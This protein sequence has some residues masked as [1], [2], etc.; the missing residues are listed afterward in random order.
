MAD[1]KYSRMKNRK[2]ALPDSS[3]LLKEARRIYA[4]DSEIGG[5]VWIAHSNPAHPG[6]AKIGSRVGGDD[7]HGY[8]MCKLLG[9]SFKVHQVV[10][11]MH[12]GQFPGSPIDHRD[13]NRRNNRIENLR[14]A[15][16]QQNMVNTKKSLRPYCGVSKAPTGFNA[17][18]QVGGKKIY[19]GFFTSADEAASA[20]RAACKQIHGEF[21]AS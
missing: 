7:G 18:I 20:Y 10:W 19:L 17:R 21:S 15:S 4:Y 8:L 11:L 13:R 5:L 2:R 6:R 16:D 1:N 12:K 14:L 3:E 9:S